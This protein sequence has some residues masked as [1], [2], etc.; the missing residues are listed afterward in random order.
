MMTAISVYKAPLH[1]QIHFSYFRPIENQQI[2]LEL[3]KSVSS[4]SNAEEETE[5]E[6]SIVDLIFLLGLTYLLL[7]AKVCFRTTVGKNVTRMMY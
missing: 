6:L 7:L 4:E 5:A 1:L 2:I 3:P